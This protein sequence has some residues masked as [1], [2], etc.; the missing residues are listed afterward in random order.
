MTADRSPTSNLAAKIASLAFGVGAASPGISFSAWLLALGF[1]S[2][3]PYRPT[4]FYVFEA[5]AT[6]LPILGIIA[7]TAL[8]LRF[9]K[10][11][12]EPPDTFKRR[13]HNKAKRGLGLNVAGLLISP[14][15]VIY[16][17]IAISSII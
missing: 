8:L 4:A 14:Y 17:L 3:S 2:D 1:A 12:A 7:C 11:D 10:K 6:A 5:S 16:T 9:R 15:F 13:V